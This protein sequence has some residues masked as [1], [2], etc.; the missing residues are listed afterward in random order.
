MLF[1]LANIRVGG[2]VLLGLLMNLDGSAE[3]IPM[4]Q[5]ALSMGILCMGLQTQKNSDPVDNQCHHVTRRYTAKP[6]Q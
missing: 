3:A 4:V 6:A 5:M 2:G 1:Y